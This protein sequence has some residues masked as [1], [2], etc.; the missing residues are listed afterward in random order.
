MLV[1]GLACRFC[2]ISLA[3]LV[4]HWLEHF[5]SSPGTGKQL[6]L[7]SEGL[8]FEMPSAQLRYSIFYRSSPVHMYV[9]M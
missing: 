1:I 3:I 9:G 7:N 4:C 6:G 8:G 5:G 2:G